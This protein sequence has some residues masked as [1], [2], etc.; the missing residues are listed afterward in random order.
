MLNSLLSFL[1]GVLELH[2][3]LGLVGG[4]RYG[5]NFE[6]QVATV[7][8]L[9]GHELCLGPELSGTTAMQQWT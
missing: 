4:F 3:D 8:G 6:A 7:T 2:D 5:L 1:C 9:G